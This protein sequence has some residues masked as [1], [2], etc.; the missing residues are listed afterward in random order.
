L[1]AAAL[2][3]SGTCPPGAYRRARIGRNGL[4]LAQTGLLACALAVAARGDTAA[5]LAGTLAAL[6]VVLVARA[7]GSVT[8]K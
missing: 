1:A 5:S 6:L 8:Q 7:A 3:R 4:I 2:C